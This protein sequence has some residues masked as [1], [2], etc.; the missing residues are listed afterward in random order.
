LGIP[1]VA[2]RRPTVAQPFKAGYAPIAFGAPLSRGATTDRSPAFQGWVRARR[3][4]APCSA[5]DGGRGS[6]PG[7][8][9]DAS[10]GRAAKLAFAQRA[11]CNAPACTSLLCRN[12][13]TG[14]DLR[15]SRRPSPRACYAAGRRGTNRTYPDRGG[16]AEPIAGGIRRSNNAAGSIRTN[17]RK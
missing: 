3:K 16:L 9:R 15:R 12:I 17:G 4:R 1:L 8:D 5:T 10:A 13:P 14:R 7:R 2:E 6:E 11:S